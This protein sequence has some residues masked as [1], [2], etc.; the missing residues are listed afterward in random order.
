MSADRVSAFCGLLGAVCLV[1]AAISGPASAAE[2]VVDLGQL[3][4]VQ[5]GD[6][7]TRGLPAGEP[8]RVTEDGGNSSPRWSASGQWLAFRKGD[9]LWLAADRPREW[10][11]VNDGAPVGAFAWS[12]VLDL[13]AYVTAAGELQL[14]KLEASA[15]THPVVRPITVPTAGIV[16]RLAWS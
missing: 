8:R 4:Y 11:V 7:W 13:L 5:D 10:W 16:G 6:I 12:P 1:L 2:P 3:A 14:V 9:Q 15:G